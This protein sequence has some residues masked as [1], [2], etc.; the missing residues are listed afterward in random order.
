MSKVT[1]LFYCPLTGL[2]LFGGHRGR[3]WLKNRIRIFKQF[4]FPSLISQTNGDFTLWVSVRPEDRNDPIVADFRSWLINS[5]LK[6]VFTYSGVCFWDDKY[7]DEV[8]HNRLVDSIHGAVPD[9]LDEIEDSEEILMTIQPSD[10]CYHGDSAEEVRD[11]FTKH[12]DVHVFGYKRGYVM[13]YFSG[14]VREWNPKTTPPFYTIRFKKGIFIDPLKHVQYTG[15]YHSHEYV[16]DFLPSY[17]SDRRGF[18]VGTHSE[19]IST[20]FNHPFAGNEYFD[21]RLSELLWDFGLGYVDKLRLPVSLRKQFM[22]KLPVG[23]QK[24]LRY[25]FG[26]RFAAKIYAFLRS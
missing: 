13:D 18:L 19:N 11:F 16:K 12:S 23:W 15:P 4:V 24:K 1:H 26:E 2:G 6:V 14:R 21:T 5:P 8:A 7:P 22:R 9:L 3:R 17:Y 20:V 10:D 25:W